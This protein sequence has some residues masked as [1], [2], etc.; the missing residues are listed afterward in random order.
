[1]NEEVC[2]VAR[3]RIRIWQKKNGGNV[4]DKGNGNGVDHASQAAANYL[5]ML[6]LLKGSKHIVFS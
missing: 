2:E 3:K 6:A 1:S 5:L 4:T